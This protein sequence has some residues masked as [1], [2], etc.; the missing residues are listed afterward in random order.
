MQKTMGARAVRRTQLLGAS[1]HLPFVASSCHH[2]FSS[3]SSDDPK[4]IAVL[5]GGIAGLSSAYFLK[6]E[7]PQ[8]KITIFEAR[9]QTG[10]WIKSMRANL[11]P[12]SGHKGN[13]LFELGP[14]TLRNSTPTAHMIQELGIVDDI[15]YT[16]KSDPGAKNRFIYYPDRLNRLPAEIPTIGDTFALAWSGILNGAWGLLKEPLMPKRSDIITDE[17]VGSFISR[18]VDRRLANNIVSAVFHGIYA[19]DIWKLSAK[20]LLR[21]PWQLEGRYGSALGGYFNMHNNPPAEKQ[22]TLVHPYDRELAK[23]MNEE[24]D[25]DLDFAKNLKSAAMFSFK[26]G[27]QH[28]VKSLQL[29]LEKSGNID[30]RTNTPVSKYEPPESGGGIQI[31]VSS[32]I[33]LQTYHAAQTSIKLISGSQA[34]ARK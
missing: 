20:T 24:I 26:D 31:V 17:T 1:S 12:E 19:G 4:R 34:Q 32:G 33:F 8:C 3:T 10:G 27:L 15:V 29:D 25:L 6:K 22:L 28:L 2:R 16:K 13:V 9:E 14:R 18:R 5:G 7:F 11:P 30:I 23:A 21:L